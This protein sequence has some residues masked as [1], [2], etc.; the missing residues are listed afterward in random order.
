MQRYLID[1]DICIDVLKGR[2]RLE[3]KLQ[4][5]G[6]ENCFISEVTLLE[7]SFGAHHSNDIDKHLKDIDNVKKLFRVI[8]ISEVILVYGKERSRLTKI[9]KR[10]P[11]L[12]LLIA[13]T[14]VEYNLILVTGNLKHHNRVKDIKIENWRKKE[15]NKFLS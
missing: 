5:V 14:S 6:L 2:F 9:G 1:T 7:F 10:I 4:E 3:N 12:D 8:P 13:V 11:D 15:F